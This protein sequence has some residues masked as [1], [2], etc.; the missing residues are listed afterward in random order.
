MTHP[1]SHDAIIHPPLLDA[2]MRQH[3]PIGHDALASRAGLSAGDLPRELRRLTD[4]GCVIEEHPQH[5]VRLISSGLGSWVDVVKWRC[6]MARNNA[7]FQERHVE[8]YR[9]TG[10]TQDRARVL[11]ETLGHAAHGAVVAADEQS[12]GRGRLG[13]RWVA[14]PGKAVTF[15]LVNILA[16]ARG[17]ANATIDQHMFATAVA[18]ARA[19][20]AFTQPSPI[21]VRIKWP[22]D[23]LVGGKK[24]AGILVETLTH[25]PRNSAPVHAAIIGIGINVSVRPDDIPDPAL[26]DR[27]TSLAALGHHTDRLLVLTQLIQHMHDALHTDSLATLIHEWRRRATIP[28]HMMEWESNGQRIRGHVLDLDPVEGLIVRTDNG[29]TLHLPAATTTVVG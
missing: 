23:I 24:L 6:P 13:R 12:A 25:T 19:A 21:E 22:N 17:H 3:E 2:L 10:S 20:E 7:T 26:R 4:A 11:I 28:A 8:V 29:V 1:I 9:T 18:V 15:T 5:G 14:P 27:I 16:P